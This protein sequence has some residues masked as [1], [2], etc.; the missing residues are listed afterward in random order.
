MEITVSAELAKQ[1]RVGQPSWKEVVGSFR[2]AGRVEAD[3]RRITRVSA[4]VGGRVTELFAN[5]GETAKKGQILATLRSA[6]LSEAQSQ[7]LKALTQQQYGQRAVDRAQQLLDAGVIGSAELQR[8]QTE[9]TQTNGEISGYQDHLRLLGM[10]DQAIRGL[11]T[12]RTLNAQISVIASEEGTVMERR[13]TVGQIVEGADILFVLAD[14]STLWI[15]ADVPEQAAANLTVGKTAEA[16]LAAYPGKLIRGRISFVSALVNPETRTV[17]ARMD[18]VNEGRRY[19]PSMLATMV[20]KDGAQA[21]LVVPRTALVR[22][23]DKDYVLAETKTGTFSLKP[24]TLAGEFDTF[25]ILT[26]GL[27][28]GER[29]ILDGA[30]HVNNERKRTALM[31]SQ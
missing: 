2:V 30:F 27:K 13:V 1:I 20:L 11:E 18:V 31:G 4:P 16:E 14:L 26:D 5:P 7:L 21:Q 8:R 9:L 6:Q 23:D 15:T 3:E 10:T 19:K 28:E 12:S 17:Q 24:V 25:R 22:E 29:I